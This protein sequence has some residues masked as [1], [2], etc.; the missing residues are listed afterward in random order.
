MDGNIIAIDA[1]VPERRVKWVSSGEDMGYELTPP[2]PV[3]EKNG[4]V[5]A[6]TDKADL[7]LSRI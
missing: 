3:V 6:P 4:V 1:T 5:Y 2:T 7:R